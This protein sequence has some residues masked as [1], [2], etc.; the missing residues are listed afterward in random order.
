MNE[1]MI[2]INLGEETKLH[3]KED[4]NVQIE[5]VKAEFQK[6]PVE[7]ILKAAE[8][9]DPDTVAEEIITWLNFNLENYIDNSV[10]MFK[11]PIDD[12]D[13]GVR[14][15]HEVPKARPECYPSEC[16][17]TETKKL[18]SLYRAIP[19]DDADADDTALIANCHECRMKLNEITE[20][21]FN[22]ISGKKDLLDLL[23]KR[24]VY[25]YE[26]HGFDNSGKE[27]VE[28]FQGFVS[29]LK[30][31]YESFSVGVILREGE[32]EENQGKAACIL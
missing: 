25:Y 20:K 7:E 16:L 10:K 14:E 19:D 9:I 1:D 4:E 18:Q 13:V 22:A 12:L 2:D 27:I 6:Y 32:T 23:Y 11:I 24:M 3:V 17:M 15:N 5:T 30:F 26:F 31:E 8:E 29:V 21:A 28:D